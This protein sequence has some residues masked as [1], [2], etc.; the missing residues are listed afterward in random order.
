M[1]RNDAFP[2]RVE[3]LARQLKKAGIEADIWHN[4][5]RMRV[6]LT[7][8]REW[9][10][11]EGWSSPVAGVRGYLEFLSKE[12][13]ERALEPHGGKTELTTGTSLKIIVNTGRGE[14][15][16]AVM[17]K[18]LEKC[19]QELMID[20]GIEG[21]DKA[22][23]IGRYIKGIQNQPASQLTDNE[24]RS[25]GNPSSITL[26]ECFY[27]TQVPYFQTWRVMA[28]T[29][30]DHTVKKGEM[31]NRQRFEFVDRSAVIVEEYEFMEGHHYP[32]LGIH[33]ERLDD[34]ES[35]L[36]KSLQSSW[37]NNTGNKEFDLTY[38]EPPHPE[39]NN[40]DITSALDHWYRTDAVKRR[41]NTDESDVDRFIQDLS[42]PWAAQL[43]DKEIELLQERTMV[44]IKNNW[45][46]REFRDGTGI[47]LDKNTNAWGVVFPVWK[48]SHGTR[49]S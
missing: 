1:N 31:N 41:L 24:V 22:V 25:P 10:V 12:D 28:D 26:A 36:Q 15:P 37:R 33:R 49:V 30:M 34:V 38:C 35:M 45:V 29:L 18:D 17:K 3:T 8:P 4:Y 9:L 19:I 16:D 2:S 44:R 47:T 40:Q 46:R 20:C 32:R 42:D 6:Y 11:P 5:G 43:T 27:H 23:P 21:D 7:L 14:T 48:L 13:I 39:L